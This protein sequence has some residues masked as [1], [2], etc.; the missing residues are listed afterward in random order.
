MQKTNRRGFIREGG[1]Y[2]LAAGAMIMPAGIAQNNVPFGSVFIHHVFFWLKEPFSA[3]QSTRF[4]SALK[5]LV[6]IDA[7]MNHHLGKPADTRREVID[8]SY[9][10][11]LLTVFKDKSA[12]DI[13]QVH[14]V[15]DAF[16]KIADE[17]CSK[18]VVFD[19]VDL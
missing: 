4:E 11:S 9:Q 1:K 14:P 3:Q 16:R 6:T 12:H 7:I 2:T 5:D 18:I 10:Y 13:Y 19:S 8:S 17:L 15:H